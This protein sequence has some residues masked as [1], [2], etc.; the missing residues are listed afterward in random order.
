VLL[1][2]FQTSQGLSQI[3]LRI[4]PSKI[5]IKEL[6]LNISYAFVVSDLA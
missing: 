3:A 5:A 1:D 6:F 4:T 2:L